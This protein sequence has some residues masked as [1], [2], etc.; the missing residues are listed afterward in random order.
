MPCS[1]ARSR[2]ACESSSDV[3]GPKFMVPRHSRLTD[4][5]LRPRCV[6]CTNPPEDVGYDGQPTAVGAQ[7]DC[8]DVPSGTPGP[9]GAVTVSVADGSGGWHNDRA[10]G[11]HVGAADPPCRVAA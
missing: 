2:I 8:V 6:Y 7:V 4:R 9:P 3:S 5:P 1:S 11:A 10:A